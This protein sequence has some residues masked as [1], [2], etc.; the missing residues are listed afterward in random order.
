MPDDGLA[1]VFHFDGEVAVGGTAD[2]VVVAHG[3][4]A[5]EAKAIDVDD[6]DVAGHGGLDE[7]GAGLWIAAHDTLLA[8][9]VVASGVDGGG[10]DG[11][12]GVDGEDGFVE[13]REL[14][15]EDGGG[16][17]VA[18]GRG[19]GAW[20]PLGGDEGVGGGMGGCGAVGLDDFA[21]QNVVDDGAF[22]LLGAAVGVFGEE[23]EGGAVDCAFEWVATEFAGELV[24]LLGEV[25]AEAGGSAVVVDGGGPVAGER[26]LGAACLRMC[27]WCEESKRQAKGKAV[28]HEVSSMRG[29]TKIPG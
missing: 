19:G 3:P 20:W 28:S 11:V 9:V 16:E 6:E 2:E 22:D 15:V 26:G 1:G 7:E 14:A 27:E 12:A 4:V 25:E 24:A 13:W 17:V 5:V 23:V 8:V 29:Y 21:L 18:L 10:V